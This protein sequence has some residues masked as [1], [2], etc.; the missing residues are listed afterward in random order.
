MTISLGRLYLV[1]A[2][3]SNVLPQAWIAHLH[4][5][6][7]ILAFATKNKIIEQK[8]IAGLRHAGA[9]LDQRRTGGVILTVDGAAVAVLLAKCD[10]TL[11]L[12][13]YA[14]N[15]HL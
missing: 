10:V 2:A 8:L 9:S 15:I 7:K 6:C 5:Q 14:S 12:R 1:K 4:T 13:L 11:C 3:S